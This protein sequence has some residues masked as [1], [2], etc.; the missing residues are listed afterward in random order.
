MVHLF[1]CLL[2][3]LTALAAPPQQVDRYIQL[4]YRAEAALRDFDQ[5]LEDA[6][7]KRPGWLLRSRAHKELM[8]LR[9]LKESI[10][11]NL[12]PR[13]LRGLKTDELG[14]AEQVAVA[15]LLENM[16]AHGARSEALPA[17]PLRSLPALLKHL[18]IHASAIDAAVE[19]ARRSDSLEAEIDATIQELA[20]DLS[21]DPSANLIQPSPGPDGNVSGGAFPERTWA[22]TYDDGPSNVN[23]APILD[24]L[25]Q[26]NKRATYFMVAEN[27]AGNQ[28]VIDRQKA[29][30]MGLECHSFT[31]ANLPKVKDAQLQKE[32]IG[33]TELATQVFGAK[34]R[35]FRLPYGSGLNNAKIRR[36]IANDNMVHVF[37][38][39]DSLDWQDKKPESILARVKKQM[40]IEKRGVILMHDIHAQTVEASRLLWEYSATLDGKPEALRWVT[41]PEVVDELNAKR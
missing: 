10:S 15:D 18:K 5:S 38:N 3:P 22:L 13:A 17:S 29:A 7:D 19:K 2:L 8:A 12:S 26:H 32:I 20:F 39:V 41:L 37:W 24:L 14:A 33:A 34:P 31:H 16:E 4:H 1:A 27:F 35:F 23:S 21:D 36:M 6:Q 11:H 40:G 30:G 9:H 28:G 25:I